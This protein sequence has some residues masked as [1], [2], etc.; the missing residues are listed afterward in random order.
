VSKHVTV[1][2]LDDQVAPTIQKIQ[3]TTLFEQIARKEWMQR[4]LGKMGLHPQQFV[5]FLELFRTLSVREE[6]A[7]GVGVNRFNIIYVSYWAALMSVYVIVFL[8]FGRAVPGASAFLLFDLSITFAA[9]FLVFVRETANSLFNPVEAAM[10][11]HAP[12]HGPTYAAS[13]I[14]HVLIA[15]LYLVLGLNLFPAFIAYFISSGARRFW[16][17][18]HLASALLIGLWTA[19]MICAVYGLIRRLV[20]ADLVRSVSKWIQI[21]SMIAFVIIPVFYNSLLHDLF[22]ARFENSQWTWLPLVWFVEVGRMGCYAASWHLGSQGALSILASIPIIWLGLRSFYGTYLMDAASA[23]VRQSSRRNKPGVFFKCF[24]VLTDAISG[25]AVALGAFF[26][27]GWMIKRDRLFWRAVLMQ[28][29]ILFLGIVLV[30]AALGHFGIYPPVHIFPHIL[31]LI[32][33]AICIN[34]P[35]TIYSNAS[36]IY[37]VAPIDNVQAFSRGI[38]GALWVLVTAMP[39]VIMLILIALYANWGIALLVCSF[40]LL[41]ASLYLAFGIGMTSGLPFSCRPN[42]SRNMVKSIYVQ[43]CG[44]MTIAL[45]IVV[46]INVW[47]KWRY[48]LIAAAYLSIA[49]LFLL[50]V[51]LKQLEKEIVWRLYLLK[52]GDN[53]IF[54]EFE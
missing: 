36:W 35:T 17:S 9:I 2:S 3:L 37:L 50:Y 22:T 4:L 26:F 29:W 38:V 53:H 49:I 20:P 48:V 6:F 27:I 14:V 19:F 54:R 34:L 7:G 28:T 18:T 52:A 10:L 43:I 12:I 5:L 31:G 40:N 25:S 45:P 33:L 30:I 47:L 21:L 1:L 8:I 23:Y 13:K 51:N 15:V 46:Q 42:E 41:V 44:I 24:T 39:N 32:I 11:A 16:F